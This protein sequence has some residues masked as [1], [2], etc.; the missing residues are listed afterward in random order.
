[1]HLLISPALRMV[2]PNEPEGDRLRYLPIRNFFVYDNQ[3]LASSLASTASFMNET[4][5]DRTM[6]R[7]LRYLGLGDALVN[8][9]P[10]DG[11]DDQNQI[12]QPLRFL[13]YW[14]ALATIVG[15]PSRAKDHQSRPHRLGLDRT[16][17]RQRVKPM[18]NIRNSF[19]VAHIDEADAAN[20]VTAED[21]TECR[22][23]ATTTIR[24]YFQRLQESGRRGS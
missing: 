8:L 4:K 1:M 7:S 15:D 10:S 21:V 14:K 24:T 17:F 9:L 3:A 22:D 11:P 19:D 23:V 16:F 18:H 12:I 6:R 5:L 13:Q 20:R 2:F